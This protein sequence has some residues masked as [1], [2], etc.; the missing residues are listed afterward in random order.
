M[1]F[2]NA[3]LP[4]LQ[5]LVALFTRITSCSPALSFHAVCG[6]LFCLGPLG[7][8]LAASHLTGRLGTSF[9]GALFYSVVSPSAILSPTIRDDVHGIWNLRRLHVLVY[10]GEAPHTATLALLPFAI[11]FLSRAFSDPRLRWKIA[12]GVMMSATVLTNAFGA[13][14]LALA[15]VCLL[16]TAGA[17]ALWRN[18][19]VLAGVSLLSYC[20]IS[21]WLPPSLL[22][23]ISLN[24]PTSG[25]DYRVTIRSLIGVLTVLAGCLLLWVVLSR[26][27][28]APGVRFFLLLALAVSGITLLGADAGM[29]VVPQ[30]HRYHLSMDMFLSMAAAFTATFILDS[31]LRR[32]PRKVRTAALALA[33]LAAGR[34]FIH[35]LRFAD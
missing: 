16:V 19:G 3:Y 27:R 5:I 31:I 2:Q 4:F 26:S 15:V 8:Y 7:L 6:F 14:T 30:P 13:V 32:V 20:W 18:A 21:P 12:A 23:A 9:F 35:A 10:Y 34:Q 24:S 11:L 29:F 17:P 22:G 25:G 33:L 1:P 28:A